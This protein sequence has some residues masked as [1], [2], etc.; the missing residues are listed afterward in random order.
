MNKCGL[1]SLG[2]E[3]TA[4]KSTSYKHKYAEGQPYKYI[5]FCGVK[6]VNQPASQYLGIFFEC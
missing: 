6:I 5:G 4:R 2:K 1:K 3:A